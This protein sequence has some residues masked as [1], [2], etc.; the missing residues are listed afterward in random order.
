MKTH[1]PTFRGV[2]WMALVIFTLATIAVTSSCSVLDSLGPDMS[3][4]KKCSIVPDTTGIL[5]SSGDTL[6]LM[7]QGR[8]V[9]K[10]VR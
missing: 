9:C 6:G 4:A 8:K 7:I 1:K 2:L 5:S 10:P 3:K